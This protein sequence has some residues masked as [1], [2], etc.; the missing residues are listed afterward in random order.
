MA[1]PASPNKV[2]AQRHARIL[3]VEASSTR[4]TPRSTSWS[5]PKGRPLTLR[6]DL[7]EL[8]TRGTEM[9]RAIAAYDPPEQVG[10]LTRDVE[11]W[12]TD[13]RD[14]LDDR[15]PE[16]TAYFLAN[17][18][19][20]GFMSQYVDKSNLENFMRHRMERLSDIVR[21]VG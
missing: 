6:R 4:R 3:S 11:K 1:P 2:V 13:V 10:A 8:L 9:Q 12:A 15:A 16:W 21:S 17:S 14:F 5:G 18:S 20:T 19:T 7:G